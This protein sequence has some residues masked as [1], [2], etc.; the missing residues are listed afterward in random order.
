MEGLNFSCRCWCG[1]DKWTV[2][3]IGHAWA[4]GPKQKWSVTVSPA[5]EKAIIGYPRSCYEGKYNLFIN[6]VDGGT[7]GTLRQFSDDTKLEREIAAPDGCAVI[8]RD[9]DKLENRIVRNFMKFNKRNNQVLNLGEITPGIVQAQGQTAGKQLGNVTLALLPTL[10]VLSSFSQL[11]PLNNKL[12]Y[13]SIWKENV[14]FRFNF[15]RDTA[16]SLA[17][18]KPS[19]REITPTSKRNKDGTGSETCVASKWPWCMHAYRLNVQTICQRK[20]LHIICKKGNI[21]SH[22]L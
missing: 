22:E 9:L 10:V 11:R 19:T 4:A 20:I 3:R 14:F 7:V 1:L 2:R 8:Q 15:H 13:W 16:P 17:S 6:Y 5:A 12:M 21:I 18:T